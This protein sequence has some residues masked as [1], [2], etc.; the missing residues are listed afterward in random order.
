[1][2]RAP[3]KKTEAPEAPPPLVCAFGTPWLDH[4]KPPVGTGQGCPHCDGYR[5]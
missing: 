3:K 4:F 2:A 1:M 5:C